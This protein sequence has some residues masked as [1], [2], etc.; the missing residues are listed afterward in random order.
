MSEREEPSTSA[1][2]VLQEYQRDVARRTAR[3]KRKPAGVSNDP[4][5]RAGT[6]DGSSSSEADSDEPSFLVKRRYRDPAQHQGGAAGFRDQGEPE[7]PGQIRKPISRTVKEER[8]ATAALTE[9]E[10][11]SN[12]KQ[13]ALGRKLARAGF[14]SV[15]PR[16]GESLDEYMARVTIKD[17]ENAYI[18]AM[19]AATRA[20]GRGA[21]LDDVLDKR[22]RFNSKVLWNE[23]GKPVGALD[24]GGPG[25]SAPERKPGKPYTTVD[26]AIDI[27]RKED[28]EM[29]VRDTISQVLGRMPTEDE[30]A[31]FKSVLNEE[32]RDHPSVTR[33]TNVYDRFGA[34]KDSRTVNRGGMSEG[35]IAA[36][37]QDWAERQPGAAEWQAV[38]TYFPEL[39]RSLAGVVQ[40][41]GP[42]I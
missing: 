24:G 26:R 9:F 19:G 22:T 8:T 27:Y 23:K 14:I 5:P 7:A 39:I 13:R 16:I 12:A 31:D 11:L 21:T 18:V 36:A 35:A 34:V 17:I 10:A 4:P 1:D 20:K 41:A 29:L 25:G 42:V 32:S 30:I 37:A 15:D 38:G 33:T 28:V 40:P 2:K 3:K 6:G